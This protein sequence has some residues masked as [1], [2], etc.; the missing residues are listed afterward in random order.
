[1]LLKEGLQ[2]IYAIEKKV[3]EYKDELKSTYI[4]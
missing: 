4:K 3:G 1:M 2:Y